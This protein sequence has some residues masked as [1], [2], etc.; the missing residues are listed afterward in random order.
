MTFERADILYAVKE[1][2]RVTSCPCVGNMIQMKRLVR[3]LAG[4]KDY[5]I[6]IQKSREGP[7]KLRICCDSNWAGCK[8][9]RKS[10]H[11][12]GIFVGNNCAMMTCR[13]QTLTAYSSG[14][15]EFYAAVSGT[16]EGLFLH[17]LFKFLGFVLSI[18]LETDASAAKAM[19]QR[20]GVGSVKT[21]E[22]KTLWLQEKIRER[23]IG[24]LKVG[25]LDNVADVGT[26][27][28]K[29]DR[30]AFLL[31]MIGFLRSSPSLELKALP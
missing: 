12:Y 18:Q 9:T 10:T 7:S 30:I 14:E 24:V 6:A 17:G 31:K 15:A 19:S 5:C 16:A 26:K 1:L 11:C 8:T 13:T 29:G 3:Y 2:G 28:L 21:L 25:T 4:T 22:A 27:R 20:L 23:G